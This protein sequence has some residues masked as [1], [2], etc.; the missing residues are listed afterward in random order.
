MKINCKIKLIS[1]KWRKYQSQ[2]MKSNDYILTYIEYLNSV[3]P[4]NY[5]VSVFIHCTLPG[6][7]GGPPGSKGPHPEVKVL[8]SE[9]KVLHSEVKVLCCVE[10]RAGAGDAGKVINITNCMYEKWESEE[11][12][13]VNT[14]VK[15]IFVVIYFLVLPS[16]YSRMTEREG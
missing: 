2:L 14:P 12:V 8:H 6:S 10:E 4:Q 3:Y 16:K 11:D 7:K 13:R 15:Q 9:V 5:Y 1:T